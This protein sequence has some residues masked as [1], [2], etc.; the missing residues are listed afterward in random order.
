[1]VKKELYKKILNENGTELDHNR[2][3]FLKEKIKRNILKEQ[4]EE[5]WL[6]L[7]QEDLNTMNFWDLLKNNANKM[8][9]KK[10]CKISMTL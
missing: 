3:I 8:L 2:Y 4:G 6:S 10:P 1:M 9:R 5:I 7:Y